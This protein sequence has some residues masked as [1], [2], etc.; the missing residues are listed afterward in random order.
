MFTIKRVSLASLL[1]TVLFLSA[2]GGSDGDFVEGDQANQTFELTDR[3]LTVKSVMRFGDG[4]V[5][6]RLRRLR[7]VAR[8]RLAKP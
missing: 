2:C 7:L 4:L 8:L 5:I 6:K 3:A 1:S